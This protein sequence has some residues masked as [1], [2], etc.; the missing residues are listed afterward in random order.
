MN[1]R[2]LAGLISS[3]ISQIL[4][5]IFL[6]FPPPNPLSITNPSSFSSSGQIFQQSISPLLRHFLSAA[7]TAAVASLLSISRKRKRAHP[8]GPD[9]PDNDDDSNPA[10]RLGPAVSRNP[11]SFSR[12]FRM[13]ASTFEWLC[14]LLEPLLDCRD[15]VGSPLNLAPETRLGIG[16]FR[17]ATGADYAEISTRFG[18]SEAVSE[19]CVRRLCRVLCTN[20]RFW[21][22]F[23]THSE[24]DSV[25]TRFETLT[26]LPNC[27]GVISCTRFNLKRG[28]NN[29]SDSIATQIVVDSSSRILS[30]VAG[31]RGNKNDLQILKSSTLYEDIENG[32]ILNSERPV[33]VNGV[34]VPRY[35]IGNGEYDLLP[36]L[37]LPF[38]DP[39]IG[40][41]EEN[42]NNA[43]RLTYVCWLKAN[44]SLRNWGVLNRPIEADYKMGVACIGSCS[45]LHNMLITREDYSAFCD[46]FDDR[47]LDSNLNVSGSE[48]GLIG[49]KASVIRKAL[50]TRAKK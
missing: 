47:I 15:P 48:G 16:L 8:T 32:V 35:L 21:V 37:L 45:I 31:F 40:S 44:A 20:Y 46:E 22:G 2:V 3:L 7:D 34:D 36:W 25:S 43:H 9:D 19:F 38:V 33:I 42:F 6:I 13:K 1:S 28:N 14:G 23:P 39:Q 11:E 30:I 12:F 4:I 17:L 27:C 29:N 5:L 10:S 49:E 50:A 26:G 41:V 18:V 24:L